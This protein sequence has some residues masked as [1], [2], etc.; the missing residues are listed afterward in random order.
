[1]AAFDGDPGVTFVDRPLSPAVLKG[2][3]RS[4]DLLVATR[5]HSAIFA[6]SSGVPTLAIGYLHKSLGIMEMLDVARHV[7]DIDTISTEQILQAFD[8]LW[9][10]RSDIRRHLNT[11]IPA[12]QTTL[13]YLPTLIRQSVRP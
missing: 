9:A 10:E 12:M 13:A 6:L 11:R 7:V 2:A 3:Y 1:M 5:M 4:L 8:T